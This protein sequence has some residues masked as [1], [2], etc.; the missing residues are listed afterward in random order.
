MKEIRNPIFLGYLAVY[1][2]GRLP[3]IRQKLRNNE[4]IAAVALSGNGLALEYVSV[5]PQ[6]IGNDLS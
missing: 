2:R 3:W 1:R 4:R 5:P 6:S